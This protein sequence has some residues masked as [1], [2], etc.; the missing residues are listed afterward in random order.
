MNTNYD[1]LAS[2]PTDKDEPSQEEMVIINNLFVENKEATATIINEMFEP[3]IVGILF[4]IFSLKY[5]DSAIFYVLPMTQTSEI[6]LILTKVVLIMIAF[7]I[8]KYF[9]LCRN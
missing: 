2:L 3:F 9:N 4:V 8:I 5:I 6:F 1:I 7:W